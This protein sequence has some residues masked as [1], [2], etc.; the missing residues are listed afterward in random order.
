MRAPGEDVLIFLHLP[1]TGGITMEGILRR[2]YGRDAVHDAGGLVMDTV[3]SADEARRVVD[4]G[5]DVVVAQG[6]EAGGHVWGEIATMP[7]V[8]AVV[9]AVD[10]PV[11][12]A[13]GIADGRGLAAA[14]ALGAGGAWVGTRFVA[15]EE[16]AAHDL[17]K[18]R[19]VEASGG[20]TVLATLFDA[21]WPDAKHRVLRT[22]TVRRWEEAGGPGP[23]TRP[24]EGEHIATL[25]EGIPLTRYSAML[26]AAD[27]TGDLEA[28]AFYAGQS[29]ELTGDVRPAGEIVREIAQDAIDAIRATASSL[30]E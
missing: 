30:R 11:L 1:R 19:I 17:Y 25:T 23:G 24:G 8:P 21:E 2:K 6:V 4:A 5:V 12:A 16:S 26:P 13:G 14:L 22:E 3:G 7:L 29:V 15:S 9:D 27:V 28:L 10:V 20:D 18:Q